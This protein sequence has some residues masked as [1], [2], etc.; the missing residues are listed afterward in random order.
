MKQLLTDFWGVLAVPI[1]AILTIFIGKRHKED[2]ETTGSM[3]GALTALTEA[4]KT[5]SEIVALQLEP[6]NRQIVAQSQHAAKQDITIAS[7]QEQVNRN[8]SMLLDHQ[9]QITGLRQ[10]ANRLRKQ[11]VS[12]GGEPVQPPKE[13][14]LDFDPDEPHD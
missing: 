1:T 3:S 5:F 4:N 10:Y 6:L 11:I 9:R 8:D 12:L 13:L 2:I 14:N 7:L